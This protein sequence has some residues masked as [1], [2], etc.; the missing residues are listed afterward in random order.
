[1]SII[2][3]L[4]ETLANHIEA[5]L[6]VQGFHWN[7]EGQDFNQFH[8]FFSDVYSGFYSEVDRLAE[9]VRIVSSGSEYVNSV[10][11]ITKTNKTLTTAI[12]V[13]D[14]PIDMCKEL[15][16]INNALLQ[17]VS[18]L[19]ES[20]TKENEQGLANYCA[21]RIDYHKKMN[22]KL[23]SITKNTGK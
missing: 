4:K 18:D 23:I 19:F 14:K 10:V 13:G 8:D 17:N 1:M 12:I 5:S 22:W 9:Y 11:D 6:S 21:D 16:N 7:I 20:A 2:D 3:K 15:I